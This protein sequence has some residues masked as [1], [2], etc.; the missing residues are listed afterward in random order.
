MSTT[1]HNQH[2]TDHP[3]TCGLFVREINHPEHGHTF[4][5][6]YASDGG[7]A[8]NGSDGSDV[9]FRTMD[10]ALAWIAS[11]RDDED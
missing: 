3:E 8:G 10:E 2:I 9:T 11:R 4:M 1:T 6:L 5:V 7:Y